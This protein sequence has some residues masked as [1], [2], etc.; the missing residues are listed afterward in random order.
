MYYFY[1]VP[2]HY[3]PLTNWEMGESLK[4]FCYLKIAPHLLFTFDHLL[5]K[6][7]FRSDSGRWILA[8]IM[9]L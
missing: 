9:Y 2:V 5:V 8:N 4:L 1:S 6:L 3:F 7:C